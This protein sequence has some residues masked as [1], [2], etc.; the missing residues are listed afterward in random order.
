MALGEFLL[1]HPNFV[2]LRSV[3]LEE[4]EVRSGTSND[5]CPDMAGICLALGQGHAPAIEELQVNDWGIVILRA[6][7]PIIGQGK[8]PQLASLEVHGDA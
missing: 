3:L 5:P 1:H 7:V 2:A 4:R 8:L 6:L